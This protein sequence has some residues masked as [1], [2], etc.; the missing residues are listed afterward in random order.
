MPVTCS[1]IVFEKIP[2][3][4]WDYP[5]ATLEL[6]N[7]SNELTYPE[8]THEHI[9]VRGSDSSGRVI[10]EDAIWEVHV[11]VNYSGLYESPSQ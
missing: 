4:Q 2:E 7:Q 5:A 1:P 10:S 8:G 6:Y 11:E 3:R 9:V